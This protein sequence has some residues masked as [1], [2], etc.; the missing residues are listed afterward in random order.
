MSKMKVI[1][2]KKSFDTYEALS[3]ITFELTEATITGLIGKN[4]AGKTTLIKCL[5]LFYKDYEGDI[6]VD[7]KPI[8]IS[9]SEISYIP[10]VPVYYEELTLYEHLKFVSSM[11]ETIDEVD[12]LVDKLCLRE[13]LD[14]FP[15]E[16]SKGTLQRMMV[17]LSL[18]R[19]CKVLIA[20]EP[21]SGLDPSQIS[22]LQNL[23]LE[24]KD[25]GI[26]ILISSHQLSIVQ[27]ICNRYVI[28][29]NGKT[30]YE[31]SENS[32]KNQTD[33]IES[34]YYNLLEKEEI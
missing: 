9:S 10:D 20:D 11:Y 32:L 23:F 7:E 1:E 28:I 33:D 18:L 12:A 6:L 14:K 30:I 13:Y 29:K 17:I 31:T 26:T 25:K 16:L 24:M 27:E 3:D 5:T 8:N 2:L 15:Q 19:K 22:A 21:F 34:L 4:G